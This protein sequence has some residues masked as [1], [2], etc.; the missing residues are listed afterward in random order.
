MGINGRK[1]LP[2]EWFDLD[3]EQKLMDDRYRETYGEVE[4]KAAV[5]GWKIEIHKC[6]KCENGALSYG[7]DDPRG[8]REEGLTWVECSY[9]FAGW[10]EEIE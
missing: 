5:E 8:N 6:P 7:E 9:C 1:S 4:L 10:W 3:R 2:P